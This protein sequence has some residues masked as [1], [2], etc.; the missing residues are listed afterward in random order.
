MNFIRKR[1]RGTA[2]RLESELNTLLHSGLLHE[3]WHLGVTDNPEDIEV[4]IELRK[5]ATPTGNNM[6]YEVISGYTAKIT[7]REEE[8]RN[9]HKYLATA[10]SQPLHGD[11]ERGVAII[12]R[13]K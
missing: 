2:S 5:A 4:G 7:A 1:I 12:Q 9:Q 11:K 6:L 8:L 10:F 3:V 13:A